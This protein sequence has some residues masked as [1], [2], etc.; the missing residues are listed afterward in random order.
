MNA[1]QTTRRAF[2]PPDLRFIVAKFASVCRSCNER[3]E[4]G[5]KI[6]YDC[7]NK[8]ITAC[9]ACIAPRPAVTGEEVF[10]IAA[11]VR[12]SGLDADYASTRNGVGFSKYHSEDGHALATAGANT[13]LTGEGWKRAKWLVSHY[14]KQTGGEPNEALYSAVQGMFFLLTLEEPNRVKAFAKVWNEIPVL[15][16]AI[17]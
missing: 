5:A 11:L 2:Q 16:A 13:G 9:P 4:V 6:T 8:R 14:R 3:V 7:A 17:L 15:R 12:L 1:T 10:T